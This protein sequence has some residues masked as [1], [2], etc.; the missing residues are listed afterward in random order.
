MYD[1]EKNCT[2]IN[3]LKFSVFYEW[4]KYYFKQIIQFFL[5]LNFRLHLI[6]EIVQKSHLISYFTECRFE[7][8][9]L[10]YQREKIKPKP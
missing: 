6:Q 7:G 4:K 10:T 9:F 1:F 5:L 8:C 3:N 2:L